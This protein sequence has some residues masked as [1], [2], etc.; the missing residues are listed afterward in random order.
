MDKSLFQ[1]SVDE[2]KQAREEQLKKLAIH[3]ERSTNCIEI[4][5]FFYIV[6]IIGAIAVFVFST[7][8]EALVAFIAGMLL[9]I[10]YYLKAIFAEINLEH[11]NA[12]SGSISLSEGVMKLRD[13]T[14]Q[15][16]NL[17]MDNEK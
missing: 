8:S 5:K 10:Y 13:E 12:V 6:A 1:F 2:I 7:W 16:R 11:D 4:S 17:L 14:Q 9:A 15:L 3:R